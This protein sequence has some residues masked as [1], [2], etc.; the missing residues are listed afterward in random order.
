MSEVPPLSGPATVAVKSIGVLAI[1]W[2]GDLRFRNLYLDVE[3][4]QGNV[5]Q[6]VPLHDALAKPLLSA[7][8]KG[9][10]STMAG[11]IVRGLYDR[12]TD[13]SFVLVSEPEDDLWRAIKHLEKVPGVEDTVA[14]L[15]A[16][17][18]D[19][20]RLGLAPGANVKRL[21][22]LGS[23]GA[24]AIHDLVLSKVIT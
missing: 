8:R 12:T 7:L 13:E 4:E 21:P 23:L 16:I 3:D 5:V 20:V 6:H 2:A 22:L 17:H 9:D 18:E 10:F 11:D 14:Q 15:K 1:N 24:K 19:R